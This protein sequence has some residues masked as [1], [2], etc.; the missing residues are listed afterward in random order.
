MKTLNWK[1]KK[2]TG[3]R[4]RIHYT[5][6]VTRIRGLFARVSV[7]GLTGRKKD[8]KVLVGGEDIFILD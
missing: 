3:K 5:S 4:R 7:L 1:G 8:P 2:T 6:R